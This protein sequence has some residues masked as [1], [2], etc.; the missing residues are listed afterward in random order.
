M[1]P[2]SYQGMRSWG[3]F[4]GPLRQAIHRLK[5]QHDIGLGEILARPLITLLGNLDWEYD[6][7]LPVPL[8]VARLRERG[9]NQAALLARP[10]ALKLGARYQPEAIDR[11]KETRSQVGL[12]LTQRRENVKNAFRAQ[13][14]WVTGKGILLIDDVTTSGSTLESCAAAL[15]AAGAERVYG[16]TLARVDHRVQLNEGGI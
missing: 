4:G 13:A 1:Q 9:Y 15:C 11:V 14:D 12:N 6:L 16:L 2:P 7:V 3:V 5:Y 10:V 8:G